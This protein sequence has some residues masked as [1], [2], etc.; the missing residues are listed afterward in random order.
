MTGDGP[1]PSGVEPRSDSEEIARLVR[2]LSLS[3]DGSTID[4]RNAHLFATR[5][6]AHLGAP[7]IEALADILRNWA[8]YSPGAFIMAI[9]ALGESGDPRAAGPLR[10]VVRMP[11]M[12]D[13]LAETFRASLA[14]AKLGAAGSSAL[15]DVVA[16]PDLLASTMWVSPVLG[17]TGDVDTALPP[18]LA[19]LA[20][21]REDPYSAMGAIQGLGKLR[22]PKAIPALIKVLGEKPPVGNNARSALY[23]I[24]E[25]SIPALLEAMTNGPDGIRG[26][27]AWVLSWMAGNPTALT[28]LTAGLESSDAE[29][30][31]AAICAQMKYGGPE[32]LPALERIQAHDE[33]MSSDFERLAT[34]AE[35]AVRAIKAREAGEVG[36]VGDGDSR[37]SEEE[38][39][40]SSTDVIA[41]AEPAFPVNDPIR[42]REILLAEMTDDSEFFQ[43]E[44]AAKAL[45]RLGAPGL[46]ILSKVA[47]DPDVDSNARAATFDGLAVS[48]DEATA[49]PI[50]LEV[51]HDPADDWLAYRA[52]HA[53]GVLGSEVAIPDLIAALSDTGPFSSGAEEALLRIGLASI[54]P[55]MDL[56]V[57]GAE[58]TH[59]AAARVLREFSG[60]VRVVQA[61]TSALEDPD[62]EVRKSAIEGLASPHLGWVDPESP[63]G[64]RRRSWSSGDFREDPETARTLVAL[65]DDPEAQVRSAAYVGLREVGGPDDA[66]LLAR[67]ERFGCHPDTAEQA[68]EVA[69]HLRLLARGLGKGKGWADVWHAARSLTQLGAPGIAAVNAVLFDADLYPD[70][71]RMWAIDVL[72]RSGDARAVLPLLAA[73]RGEVPPDPI[74]IA[75]HGLSPEERASMHLRSELRAAHALARL[76][77]VGVAALNT[78]LQDPSSSTVTRRAIEDALSGLPADGGPKVDEIERR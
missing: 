28:G 63:E 1:D 12:N 31:A 38:D 48:G 23:E 64:K 52:A 60:D 75:Y 40:S 34:L 30:R 24:G 35:Q 65:L 37:T 78:A 20:K 41:V 66:A 54:P 8:E 4:Q 62:P 39:E 33:S 17:S 76:G 59:W 19:A 71:S 74:N 13:T 14:L 16:T 26:G 50:L 2:M 57:S 32:V 55:L 49:L 61:L 73:L 72:G 6:L 7:G 58:G 29:V 21:H 5:A 15:A 67:A 69:D 43:A 25:P 9:H 68:S 22:S 51:L 45:A 77:P 36:E 3:S 56:L 27:A 70:L 18:L 46:D 44:A 47:R 10:E 42:L 11:P 53:L